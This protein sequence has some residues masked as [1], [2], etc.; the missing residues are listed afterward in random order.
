V[1]C[2]EVVTMLADLERAFAIRDVQVVEL[3]FF[4][5]LDGSSWR[6]GDHDFHPECSRVIADAQDSL[7]AVL[8][9]TGE[10]R[11]WFLPGDYR[12][13]FREFTPEEAVRLLVLHQRLRQRSVAW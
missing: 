13:L 10:S 9:E 6:E 2:P 11:W 8:E 5:D 4:P 7:Q 12:K 1:I 3:I